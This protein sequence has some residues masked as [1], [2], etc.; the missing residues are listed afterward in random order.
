MTG[1]R[2]GHA[3]LAGIGYVLIFALAMHANFAVLGA[4]PAAD[5]PDAVLAFAR[6]NEATLRLAVLEFLVVMAVD[7]V[8]ALALFRLF[9]PAS[10]ILN[11]LSAAFRLVYTTANIP[12]ILG[13][14]SALRWMDA[15]D[16]SLAAAMTTEAIDGYG[17]GFTLTLG[18]FGV[19]LMLLGVLIVKTRR[20]PRA[21]GLLVALAGLGY[22]WD[23][24][25]MLAFPALRS[26]LGDLGVL[27]VI[28]PALLGEGLLMLWLLFGPVRDREG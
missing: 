17:D 4:A 28:A 1:T 26:G 22:L 21:L 23:A 16:P 7:V 19:H 3:R 27:I 14:A 13:L 24:V 11:G 15:P 6:A 9:E 25:G 8:V 20:L 2:A 18:F 5:D 12:V 10:P